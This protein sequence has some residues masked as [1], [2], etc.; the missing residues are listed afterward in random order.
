MATIHSY[1]DENQG[2]LI[3]SMDDKNTF[4]GVVSCA[5]TGRKLVSIEQCKSP[6]IAFEKA[7][8]LAKRYWL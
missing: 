8:Q 3:R 4:K 6:E 1:V 5:V 7:K 2:L